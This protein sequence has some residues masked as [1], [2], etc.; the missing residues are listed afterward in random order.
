MRPWI[1][2]LEKERIQVY[3][4]NKN[5]LSFFSRS[6]QGSINIRKNFAEFRSDLLSRWFTA[7]S[8]KNFR[9]ALDRYLK[10]DEKRLDCEVQIQTE[11]RGTLWCLI[12]GQSYSRDNQNKIK[13]LCGNMMVI[14]DQKTAKK[15]LEYQLLLEQLI[16]QIA[17]RFININKEVLDD[18]IHCSFQEIGRF[19]AL[20]RIF[21][22]QRS[23]DGLSYST[24]HE[25][26]EQGV[27]LLKGRYQDIS[28][29][30]IPGLLHRLKRGLPLVL[31]QK[32]VDRLAT[33]AEKDLF[34]L[35]KA[36]TL[37]LIPLIWQNELVAFLGLEKL[38][39]QE[40]WQKKKLSLLSVF[41]KVLLNVLQR[42]ESEER[43]LKLEARIRENQRLESLIVLAGGLSH[44]FNNVLNG[45][46]GNA[47]LALL[48]LMD[49]N[50][51][52]NSLL[53]IKSLTREA[54]DLSRQLLYYSGRTTF[55]KKAINLSGFLDEIKSELYMQ[56]PTEIEL[57]INNDVHI[58]AIWADPDQIEQIIRSLI[59]NAIEAIK[60]QKEKGRIRI[61]V[62][63]KVYSNELLKEFSAKEKHS[64]GL[65]IFMD[66][67]D[68]GCGIEENIINKIF[69]PFFTT[70]KEGKGL[71]LSAVYGMVIS[72]KGGIQVEST[73]G[74]GTCFTLIFPAQTYYNES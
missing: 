41:G 18:E 66:V 74:Q 30:Y 32:R 37:L 12:K 10:F 4:I 34:Q 17:S 1:W 61:E 55:Q 15:E 49:R 22:L 26:A 60:D 25:W 5:F 54:A 27:S 19:F 53:N 73:P 14:N 9:I 6:L 46:L 29:D 42:N 43:Q 70:K 64:K 36:E 62:G 2:N 20:D 8:W 58:P 23:T 35:R 65:Y 52:K 51:M 38:S 50:E 57:I 47:E 67:S 71:E 44:S 56:L 40:N 11:E 24:S 39:Y 72:H 68:N 21:L 59:R 13:E 48:D 31:N 33:A 3:G 63:A 28:K 7:E 16:S 69:D 45:I